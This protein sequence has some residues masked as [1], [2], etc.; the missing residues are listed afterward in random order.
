MYDAYARSSPLG[1]ELRAVAADNGPIGGSASHTY[2][3]ARGIRRGRHRMVQG[4]RLRG[5][6]RAGG[7]SRAACAP[8]RARELMQ[9]VA[10]PGM[11]TCEQVA[12]LLHLRSAH[13]E[14]H[15][16]Q[17]RRQ[18]HM[19]LI[20]G[21]HSLNEVKAGKVPGL[22]GFRWASDSEILPPPVLARVS[23]AVA[24][25]RHALDRRQTVAGDERFHLRRQRSGLSLACVNFGRDSREPTSWPTSAT[26]CRRPVARWQGTLD[27][28]VSKWATFSLWETSIRKRWRE[29]LGADGQS[30]NWKW[31]ARHWHYSHRR[32]PSSRISTTG[33]HL[34][35]TARAV[36]RC[37]R[38]HCFDRNEAVRSARSRF[39]TS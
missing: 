3:G 38:A 39:T 17:R 22:A 7:G 26:W 29:L 35:G 16:A 27:R 28:S 33:H 25:I 6:R 15:H 13:G 5:K 10:T 19:L 21:D 8:R 9:K 4:F 36:H 2:S 18:V 34:A 23:R 30:K 31:V 37:H 14:M 1:I 32:R 20:R 12:H 24:S 11:A